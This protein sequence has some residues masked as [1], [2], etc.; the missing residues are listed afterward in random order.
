MSTESETALG[1]LKALAREEFGDR[2]RKLEQILD[3]A[4][5]SA[6]SLEQAV[7]EIAVTSL[8]FVSPAQMEALAHKMRT[9]LAARELATPAG[10]SL[11]TARILNAR[12][13]ATHDK[14]SEYSAAPAGLIGGALGFLLFG[15]SADLH[16]YSTSS[17]PYLLTVLG[18]LLCVGSPIVIVY[19]W[20][21]I[22]RSWSERASNAGALV[23]FFGPLIVLLIGFGTSFISL[24][25]V[26]A[27]LIKLWN[28]YVG[29][30]PA[31][32]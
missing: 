1:E 5:P 6:Q 14:V 2:A 24:H 25:E 9:S 30:G 16:H 18:I 29:A 19:L 8:L 7:A 20:F 28:D 26:P 12:T 4:E 31:G 32:R 3:R 21:A 22:V 13:A 23:A 15:G 10:E 11:L 27:I 17:W